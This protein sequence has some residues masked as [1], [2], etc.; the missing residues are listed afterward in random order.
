MIAG[1]YYNRLKRNMKLQCDATVMYALDEKKEVLSY[2]DLE[3]DSPYN[4]YKYSGLPPEAIANP[5]MDSL[6]AVMSP[7][8]HEFL[9]YVRNDVK[10]DGSHVFSKTMEEHEKAIVKYQR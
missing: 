8:E 5:G 2:K 9:Y 6:K 10:N 7:A 4:T 3:I 1:V